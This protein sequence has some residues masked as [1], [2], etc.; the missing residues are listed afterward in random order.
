M[1]KIELTGR[2][3]FI[4]DAYKKYNRE[5]TAVLEASGAFQYGNGSAV[6]IEW[7]VADNGAKYQDVL[8]DTR[9]EVEIL[10]DFKAWVVDWFNSNYEKHNII[11]N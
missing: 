5:F 7:G 8:L 2:I 1:E 11:I 9:Y 3:E 6:R 4:N 10:K